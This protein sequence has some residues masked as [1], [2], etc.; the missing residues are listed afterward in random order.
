[1]VVSL[2]ALFLQASIHGSMMYS[3][4]FPFY[5]SR[6]RRMAVFLIAGL[7]FSGSTALAEK[8]QLATGDKI[9]ITLL[10]NQDVN[11]T[12]LVG[13][14][15]MVSIPGIGVVQASGLDVR[16]F[17]SRLH[18]KAAQTIVDP[19]LSVQVVE[20]RPFFIL[21]D[22]EKAGKYPFTP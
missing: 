15:G 17:E 20:Y 10:Q 13:I 12:Y 4:T 3:S 22:V 2:P 6:A 7:L 1:M 5:L 8:Y 9:S 19:S 16:A 18:K 11:D 21:G 14:D